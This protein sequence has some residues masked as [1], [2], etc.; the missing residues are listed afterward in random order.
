MGGFFMKG[1]LCKIKHIINKVRMDRRSL[2]MFITAAVT[3]LF[4]ASLLSVKLAAYSE[5][6]NYG[7]SKRLI[8]LHVVADSDS[9]EDQSL[10]LRVR[11]AVIGYMEEL[12]RPSRS[13][14]ETNRL[15][16]LNMESIKTLAEQEVRKAGKDCEVS[17]V[18]GEFPFP[19]KIYG[20]IAL[21]AGYYRAL[22]IVIG[23]GEGA[24]WWCVLFPPLCFV[25]AS[26]GTIP[27]TVKDE[28]KAALSEEEYNIVV[29]AES[30]DQI[31]VRVKFKIV[32]FFQDARI[33]LS[34]FISR[35]FNGK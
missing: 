24:N 28:L 23:E 12:I 19:T 15:L 20:D 4:F 35:L 32:E 10:K 17:A 5:S 11:D 29:S 16:E 3:V 18:L 14:E 2:L 31:P 25:D 13:V 33:K 27:D 21:P 1:K 34:G 22:K 6:I 9:E 30:E 26:H 7:L 8:R